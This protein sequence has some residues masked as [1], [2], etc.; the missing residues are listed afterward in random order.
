[1]FADLWLY[2]KHKTQSNGKNMPNLNYNPVE[3]SLL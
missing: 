3:R 2:I 1:M